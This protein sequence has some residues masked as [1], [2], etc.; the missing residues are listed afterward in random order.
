MESE[1]SLSEYPEYLSSHGKEQA[2]QSVRPADGARP[3]GFVL[4]KFA[5]AGTKVRGGG[6]PVAP[7][8]GKSMW[9]DSSDDEK[10]NE[11]LQASSGYLQAVTKGSQVNKESGQIAAMDWAGGDHAAFNRIDR[12]AT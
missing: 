9:G 10:Q 12:W 7:G 8:S 2:V 5:C 1:R 3:A 11:Q 4:S 6:D